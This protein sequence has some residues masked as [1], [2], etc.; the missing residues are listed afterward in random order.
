MSAKQRFQTSW[1][2]LF[3]SSFY[4]V[5]TEKPGSRVWKYFCVKSFC[6][7]GYRLWND[8]PRIVTNFCLSFVTQPFLN[9]QLA[10]VSE[11]PTCFWAKHLKG[12]L[13][14]YPPS[15]SLTVVAFHWNTLIPI[16]I[17]DSTLL[18]TTKTFAML[19]KLWNPL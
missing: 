12:R 1:W 15:I 8:F 10:L 3:T 5:G 11:P 9:A 2:L 14:S 16:M 7:T 19:I 18:V 4:A 17:Q 6:Y 13:Q